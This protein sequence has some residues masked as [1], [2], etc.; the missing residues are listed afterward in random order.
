MGEGR[1]YELIIKLWFSGVGLFE[2]NLK[3]SISVFSEKLYCIL[4][5]IFLLDF[6]FPVPLPLTM[7]LYMLL[8]TIAI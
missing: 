1:F 2:N 6:Y 8:L 5:S 4:V 7:F 3:L